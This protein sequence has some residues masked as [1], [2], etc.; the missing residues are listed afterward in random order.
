MYMKPSPPASSSSCDSSTRDDWV[1]EGWTAESETDGWAKVEQL[2]EV[3]FMLTK[4]KNLVM[5]GYSH[6][7]ST[8]CFEF[9]IQSNWSIKVQNNKQTL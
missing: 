8:R 4:Q 2:P 9:H 3:K 5:Q 1:K 6:V 7:N